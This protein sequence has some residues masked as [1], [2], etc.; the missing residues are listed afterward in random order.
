MRQWLGP[1]RLPL[2]RRA[3][4]QPSGRMAGPV[5]HARSGAFSLSVGAGGGGVSS[6]RLRL[7]RTWHPALTPGRGYLGLG[8]G[9]HERDQPCY[10]ATQTDSGAGMPASWCL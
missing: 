8:A 1:G 10:L 2:L 9:E 3:H 6:R 7:H 5:G 4:G